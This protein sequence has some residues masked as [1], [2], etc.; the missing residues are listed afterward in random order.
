MVEIAMRLYETA[1]NPALY[2]E[3]P[4]MGGML[5]SMLGGHDWQSQV[6]NIDR[7]NLMSGL[8]MDPETGMLSGKKWGLD[9]PGLLNRQGYGEFEPEIN[10]F[11]RGATNQMSLTGG[12]YNP[13]SL[14]GSNQFTL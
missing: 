13:Y 11:S 8:E 5:G 1:F 3:Q 10:P 9:D 7:G 2:Q 4:Q 6:G 12:G 14:G